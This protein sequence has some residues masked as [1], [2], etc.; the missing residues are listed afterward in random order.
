MPVALISTSTSPARGPSRSRVSMV[1]GWPACQAT[2][3]TVFIGA[4]GFRE[5]YATAKLL[6]ARLSCFLKDDSSN[7]AFVS[8][9]YVTYILSRRFG[10]QTSHRSKS[11][12]KQEGSEHMRLRAHRN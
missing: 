2:A 10:I 12:A 5:E 7:N 11:G 9:R 6:A 8:R 1:R 4:Y 3:A